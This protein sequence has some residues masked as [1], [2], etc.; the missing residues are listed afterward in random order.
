MYRDPPPGWGEAAAWWLRH[1][2]AGS[3]GTN[4]AGGPELGSW[5]PPV[6]RLPS[7]QRSRLSFAHFLESI[8]GFVLQ[9]SRHP[10]QMA[11]SPR[12]ALADPGGSLEQMTCLP[13]HGS[14]PPPTSTVPFA[15]AFIGIRL[16][17]IFSVCPLAPFLLSLWQ[18]RPQ[19]LGYLGFDPS[20]EP[21]WGLSP[22]HLAD[23]TVPWPTSLLSMC[24]C[25][26]FSSL[27]P[28]LGA[29]LT[30]GLFSGILFN[31]Q[32]FRDFAGICYRFLASD[33]VREH[34]MCVHSYGHTPQGSH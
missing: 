26:W 17:P 33:M 30:C 7:C 16:A 1:P 31:F 5:R 27:V 10:P 25:A 2:S 34:G 3:S 4:G 12:A 9:A 24:C 23:G 14:S 32:I 28:S 8:C 29:T 6:P 20:L 19:A 21:L 15:W 11:A 13:R 18:Q 22:G